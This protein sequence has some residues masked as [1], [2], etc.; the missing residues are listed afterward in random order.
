MAAAV[1]GGD[2]DPCDSRRP[3]GVD[4]VIVLNGPAERLDGVVLSAD[5]RLAACGGVHAR[6]QLWDLTAGRR[7]PLAVDVVP[8]SRNAFDFS[9]DG[10]LLAVADAGT[11]SL[12]D[13]ATG[14]TT[15]AVGFR[16]PRQSVEAVRFLADGR[17]L[18]ATQG[19]GKFDG[20]L[21][22]FDTARG[23]LGR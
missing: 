15:A 11:L 6:L 3:G 12:F 7:L 10:R 8:R 9:P 18:A 23:Q 14:Q 16:P 4:V 19:F 2:R 17:L 20:D 1:I 13:V 22:V 21:T 5:G